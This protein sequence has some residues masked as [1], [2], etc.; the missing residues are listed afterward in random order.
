MD[1]TTIAAESGTLDT[2]RGYHARGWAVIPI[3]R[4]SKNPG[5]DGW[6][7]E[8]WTAD[9]LPRKFGRPCNIGVLTGEPSGWL[10]DVDLDH[11]LAVE[12]APQFLPATGSIF[13]RAGKQRSHWL[14]IAS[15]GATHKR[16]AGKPHGMLV[17]LRSTGCQTVFPGSVHESGE[18]IEWDD[19][20]EPAVI[21]A[22][23]LRR[24][25]DALADEVE[26]RLGIDR[27]PQHKST[28][29]PKHSN[30]AAGITPIERAVAAME[31]MSMTDSEDGSRR[32][33]AAACRAVEHDLGDA[34]AIDAI[35]RY[36]QRQPFPRDWTDSEIAARLR[37]AEQKTQR[38]SANVPGTLRRPTQAADGTTVWR[39]L[40]EIQ[41]GIDEM[42][43]VNETIEAM[44]VRDDLHQRGGLLVEIRES[45]EPPPCIVRP[46]GG[47]RAAALS[48]WRLRELIADSARFTKLRQTED[49][50]E[51]V[52]TVVPATTVEQVLARGLWRG[53]PPL[54]GIVTSPQFLLDGS[55]LA[56]PGYDKR[57]GLY[58]ADGERF[59]AVPQSPT[60]ADAERAAVELLEVV[61]DFPIDDVGRAAWLA[62]VLTGAARHAIDGPTPLFAIDANVRGSGKSLAADSVG[63]MHTGRQLPRTSVAGNDDEM[64]KRITAILLSGEPLV[65]LDNINGVLGCAS[66]DAL[67]TSTTWTDRILGE[68]VMTAVLPAKAIWLATGNNLQFAA[69]TAR[70]T[71]RIRLESL[72]ENPEER[73]GFRH[74]NL[75]AWVRAERGRLASAAVTILRAWHVAGRPDMKLPPWGSFDSWSAIVRNAVVWCGMSDPGATRQEVQRESDREAM[76]L[77]QLLSA[78]SEADPHAK[79]LTVVDAIKEADGGNVALAGVFAELAD[80]NGKVNARSIGQKLRHLIGR[81]CGGCYFERRDT[82][83]GAA[84]LVRA[85]SEAADS[86]SKDSSDSSPSPPH[87]RTHA[88]AHTHAHGVAETT[89]TT[90]T[91]VTP[92]CNHHDATTWLVRDGK[93][94]CRGCNRWIGNVP[95]GRRN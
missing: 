70:R 15:G 75:L 55:I 32:L 9:Q 52:E 38:G 89:V 90:T 64:R 17:E 63:I 61:A 8:R 65:L 35:R 72:E 60:L 66:L 74:P 76:L 25:V 73:T 58:F 4:G 28:G 83:R 18:R 16:A 88:P 14:Y 94:Y 67:L 51:W 12:L 13:G 93:A 47:I 23:E 84:W 44:A 37:D 56:A 39:D 6:Q 48:K 53:I 82:N 59:A 57:S 86:D 2:A 78:W 40:P 21:D 77:R 5:R 43:M 49:G 29:A 26:R 85:V 92:A 80:K 11:A 68:S 27:K 10:V 1:G 22:A 71:L 62:I 41:V 42:R 69:D 19:G 95:T 31:H 24:A 81:V 3:K 20:G 91:T 54:E 36:A 33:F 50:E 87:A 7:N 79:G 46:D 30:V 45:P 34:D